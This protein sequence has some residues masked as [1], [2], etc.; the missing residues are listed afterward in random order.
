MRRLNT[1]LC[2]EP[3]APVE[4]IPLPN[5]RSRSAL[6]GMFQLKITISGNL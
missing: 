2:R 1:R 6:S 3:E 4:G 5:G